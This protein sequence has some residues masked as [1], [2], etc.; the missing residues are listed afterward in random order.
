MSD[1][2][3][4]V[5]RYWV[6]LSDVEPVDIPLTEWMHS[7]RGKSEGTTFTVVL[8]ADYDRATQ[9]L[10]DE[11]MR[12]KQIPTC[13]KTEAGYACS[14]CGT[15][16]RTDSPNGDALTSQLAEAQASTKQWEA[17]W[18][19]MNAAFNIDCQQQLAVATADNAA[20]FQH[21]YDNEGCNCH[22]IYICRCCLIIKQPHPGTALLDENRQL[23][24]KIHE[25]EKRR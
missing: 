10:K 23:K 16:L 4:D 25:Y 5:T 12:L 15:S 1:P 7:C 19:R 3:R 20:L 8:A 9:A 22:D 11:I 24:E 14:H 18:D 13:V 2:K 6:K 17:R 21:I